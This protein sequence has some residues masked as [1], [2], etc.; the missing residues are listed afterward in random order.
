VPRILTPAVLRGRQEISSW[1]RAE[2]G[3]GVRGRIV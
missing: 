3:T 1:S 2:V